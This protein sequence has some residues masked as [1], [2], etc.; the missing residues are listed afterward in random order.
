M[1]FCPICHLPYWNAEDASARY[2]PACDVFQD[3]VDWF[4]SHYCERDALPTWED[5]EALKQAIR[6]AERERRSL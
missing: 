5:V 4:L 3:D 1:K 2:C 6:D